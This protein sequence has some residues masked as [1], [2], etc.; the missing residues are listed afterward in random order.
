MLTLSRS[1]GGVDVEIIAV[2]SASAWRWLNLGAAQ[3]VYSPRNHDSKDFSH[4]SF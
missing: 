2:K 4:M 1:A 3:P